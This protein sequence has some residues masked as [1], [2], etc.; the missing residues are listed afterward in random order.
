M[1]TPRTKSAY[2]FPGQ[3]VLPHDLC[4]YY[5]FLKLKDPVLVEKFI[6]LLQSSLDQ[7]NP[8][9]KFKVLNN[10]ANEA[11]QDWERTDFVQPLIF[12]LNLLTYELIKG[13][14]EYMLGYSLG[15]FSALVASG[16][17]NIEEGTRIVAARG[18]FMQED[19]EKATKGMCTVLGLTE[20]QV[21]LLCKKTNSEIVIMSAPTAYVLGCLRSNFSQIE[22]EAAL[23]GARKVIR[24][25]TAGAF[26]SQAMLGSYNKLKDLLKDVNFSKPRIPVVINLNGLASD[27]P[28][29]L[30]ND[31]IES[32]ITPVNWIR[33]IEFLKSNEV[34]TFVEV[35]PGTAL[36]SLCRLNGIDRDQISHA[37]TIL[38]PA[39]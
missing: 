11:S 13:T 15:A 27:D 25:T 23:L 4:E 28:A 38:T 24:L 32:T 37:K 16:A 29:Q 21:N 36:S 9:S 5:T 35:G 6:N 10:L 1:Q 30:K 18:K 7:A 12:I 26:H 19:S 17:L 20:D 34:T 2:L 22:S 3:G 31:I 8:E 39:N 14:P 33:M